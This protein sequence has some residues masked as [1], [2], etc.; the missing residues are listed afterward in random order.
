MQSLVFKLPFSQNVFTESKVSPYFDTNVDFKYL[1]FQLPETSP[2]EKVNLL[3]G[4]NPSQRS[5]VL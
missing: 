4:L 3:K 1:N 5:G 2:E